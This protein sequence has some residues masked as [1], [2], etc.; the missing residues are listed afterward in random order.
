MGKSHDLATGLSY[1]DLTET[2]ARYHTKTAS[3]AAFVAKAGDTMTGALTVGGNLTVNTDA[4]TSIEFKDGGTNAAFI[5]AATGDELY[6]GANGEYAIRIKN[7]GTK[8]VA[9]DNGS[10]VTMPSQ[11]S[12]Y[13]YFTAATQFAGTGSTQK[14]ANFTEYNDTGSCW[15]QTNQRFI[16]PVAGK[17]FFALTGSYTYSSGYFFPKLTING[18]TSAV[19]GAFHYPMQTSGY[20]PYTITLVIALNANDYIEVMRDNN[21]QVTM[22][23]TNF[24]GY[25]IG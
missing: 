19:V 9:F 21:Y 7:D 4:D 3:N 18:A 24:S 17:Y 8:D 10:R 12:F 23:N 20:I 16:A 25:L 22:Y 2:D 1:Q 15:D 11:P 6:I 5:T 13:V 14:Q